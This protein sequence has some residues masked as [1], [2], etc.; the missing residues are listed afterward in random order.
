MTDLLLIAA[1]SLLC[2]RGGWWLCRRW[3][4]WQ[5]RGAADRLVAMWESER[6]E[7]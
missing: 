1:W 3:R 7:P 5:Y 6:T 4:I 2:V